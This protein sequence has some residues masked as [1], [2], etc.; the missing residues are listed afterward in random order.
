M[1]TRIIPKT[2]E[3]LPVIGCGTYRGFDV[4]HGGPQYQRLHA[5]LGSLFDAGGSVLD[6]SPMYGRSE[7]ITGHLLAESRQRSRAFIA[8]KVW[9]RGRAAGIEQMERSLQLLQVAQ[10]DLMQV[11]NLVDCATHLDTLARWK[12][13]GRTRYVGITHYHSGAHAELATVM[14]TIDI[15]F[16]Q[17]DYS[18]EDRA[19]ETRLL[20][21][22]LD[23]GIAVLVNL[24]LGGG[25]L[26]KKLARQP[27][28]A[29]AAALGCQSWPQLL[30]K[31]VL[32]HPAVTSAIPGTA[33]PDHMTAN[34]AA[35]EGDL[36]AAREQLLSWARH[37]PL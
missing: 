5:V 21:L 33:N 24:P 22:A 8:T 11:H 19:A 30:L 17:L 26:V 15:D 9:T 1:Q 7:A 29:F 12:A 36:P 23:R 18:L 13:E 3:A 28:P 10:V 14:Q 4:D 2:G 6:S 27:L 35:A 20:P 37:H 16:V 25:S 32:G 34:A 31:F